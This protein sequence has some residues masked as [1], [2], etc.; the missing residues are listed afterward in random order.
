MSISLD[1]IRQFAHET[2]TFVWINGRPVVSF[3]S[4]SCGLDGKINILFVC[5]IDR[6]NDALIGGI[7]SLDSRALLCL[8][9]FV[10]DEESGRLGIS[11]NKLSVT[12][13]QHIPK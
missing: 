7:N 13:H 6:S 8:D 5:G 10:V 2:A 9:E 3:E 1:Q 12:I 4:I 11:A